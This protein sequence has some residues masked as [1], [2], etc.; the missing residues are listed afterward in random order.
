MP[1][2]LGGWTGEPKITARRGLG[3]AELGQDGL[4]LASALAPAGHSRRR[5]RPHIGESG[6][7]RFPQPSGDDGIQRNRVVRKL[8]AC[9]GGSGG[10]WEARPH[11]PAYSTRPSFPGSRRVAATSPRE[12]TVLCLS[13]CLST[14]ALMMG[15]VASPQAG[16]ERMAASRRAFQTPPTL[17]VAWRLS[18]LLCGVCC[19]SRAAPWRTNS[20]PMP[21]CP[22]SASVH[23]RWRR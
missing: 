11:R 5:R 19:R 21:S 18:R 10:R 9:R 1:N 23:P 15:A 2:E 3:V 7:Q 14:E 4:V 16:W 13:V 6:A 12:S 20:P 8:T 17:E 22:G